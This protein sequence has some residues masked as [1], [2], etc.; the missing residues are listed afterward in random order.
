MCNESCL[1]FGRR[2]LQARHCSD[3][4]VLEVGAMNV[5][6]SLRSRIEAFLPCE[7]IGVDLEPGR[8]VDMVCRVEELMDRFGRGSFDLVIC[9]ELLEHVPDWRLAIS[10]L[11]GVLKR[12]G[13]L[14]VTTRSRGFPRHCFPD[15]YWR[16]EVEDL[17]FIFADFGDEVIERDPDRGVFF[18]GRKSTERAVPLAAYPL[19]SMAQGRRAL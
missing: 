4:R 11:K 13:H 6:G 8:G 12:G 1:Q 14:L 15:D 19:F 16:Y 18:F 5:N 10:N 2:V 3:M 7:Y 9:T 17:R